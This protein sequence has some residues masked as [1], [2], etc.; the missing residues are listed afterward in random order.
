MPN[1]PYSPSL[2]DKP[3]D[4]TTPVMLDAVAADLT[5]AE[6]DTE[7]VRTPREVAALLKS[8]R[9]RPVFD[10]EYAEGVDW[11]AGEIAAWHDAQLDGK[12]R[13]IGCSP[14]MIRILEELV[15]CFI[16]ERPP[17]G[18]LARRLILEY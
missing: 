16:D 2:T 12:A 10:P 8:W 17:D 3:Y 4:Y 11:C 1:H 14:R 15:R 5:L 6:A 18:L 9:Y 7:P 13:K